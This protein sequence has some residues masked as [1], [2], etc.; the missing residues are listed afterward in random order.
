MSLRAKIVL[1]VLGLTGVILAGL[2]AF[3]SSSFIGWSVDTLSHDLS[4]RAEAV[5][6]LIEVK[7]GGRLEVEVEESPLA[8]DAAR[9]FRVL[10][11]AGV[12]WASR[13]FPWP[14]EATTPTSTGTSSLTDAEGR[15]WQ[16]LTR[17]FELSGDHHDMDPVHVFIQVAGEETPFR[18]LGARFRQGLLWALLAA[19][20]ANLS[21]RPLRRLAAEV[22]S[23]GAH[24]LD[25]RIGVAGLDPELRRLG[26]AFN[27]LLSRLGGAMQRQRLL[28]SR[29]SHSLRTP[30]ATILTRAEVTLRR[31]RSPEEYR[32]ALA[33]IAA[34]SR[35]SA[36]L[37]GSLLTLSR[38]DERQRALQQEE[39][40]VDQVAGEV[41]RLLG[42][43][44]AEAGVS[45]SV[46]V[47]AGLSVWAER[48]A[49]REL[50][51]ALAD[52]AVHYTPRGG[53][54]GISAAAAPDGGAEVVV[55]D[56]GPGIPAEERA[57][58]FERFFRG[59]ASLGKPGSGL[60]LAIAQAIAEAHGAMLQ[61]LDRD[62]GG[63]GVH[64]AFPAPPGRSTPR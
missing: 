50:L 4:E 26:A 51:E 48:A 38:L 22:D 15:P 40:A 42:P 16:I 61:L 49:L 46:E 60:G 28:V 29:A 3:L 7:R 41:S 35:E 62:G 8:S 52:N 45:L 2:W 31:E 44:A 20:L 58:V 32:A 24:S 63:L 33:E 18:A 5:A 17:S 47:P 25:H 1:L 37:I 9:P 55:W 13:R 39:V 36:A 21:L 54:A 30:A 27:D 57:Q 19:L 34:T 6:A 43:R 59:S 53:R 14:P 56:S 23:I 11:P 10:G 12:A 64:I